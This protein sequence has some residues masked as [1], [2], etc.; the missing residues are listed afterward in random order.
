MT[1]ARKHFLRNFTKKSKRDCK[2]LQEG[3]VLI[4][5]PH[6]KKPTIL[7]RSAWWGGVNSIDLIVSA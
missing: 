5:K 6:Q 7:R 1:P 3:G 2:G 4:W